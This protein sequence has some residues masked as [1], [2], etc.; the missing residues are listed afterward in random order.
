MT[1]RN[2]NPFILLNLI[3]LTIVFQSRPLHLRSPDTESSKASN[4]ARAW[5]H[6]Q[7]RTQR[8]NI[9]TEDLLAVQWE[10]VGTTAAWMTHFPVSHL[11]APSYCR[12]V[13]TTMQSASS[14]KILQAL[15][16]Q[17]TTLAYSDSRHM[18][19]VDYLECLAQQNMRQH[20]C[21]KQCRGGPNRKGGYTN[22]S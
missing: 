6:S 11:P 20:C 21:H 12:A 3:T 16:L 7:G 4:L 10:M 5:L 22:W 8:I 15:V 9:A 1:L 13:W 18:D 17:G 2:Q 14:M 19:P